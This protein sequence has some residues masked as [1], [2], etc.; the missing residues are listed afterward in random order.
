MDSP[1]SLDSLF[2]EKLFRIPDYQRG[3]A[4]QRDQL[5][6]FWEDLVNLPND[7]TH[8]T[9][10]LTLKEV[11]STE[12]TKDANE[13]WLVDDHSY[14]LHHI[15]DGQ[16]RLTTFVIFIQ[17]LLDVIRAAPGNTDLSDEAI[18]LTESLNL[19]SIRQKY[20]FET[21]PT[22]IPY[23]TYKFGYAIDNPSY[24]FL[25]H[26]ILGESGEGTIEETFYTLNLSNA[27]RFFEEQL[28][29][30]R[31][32]RGL[33][34]I[35]EIYRKLTKRFLF[36]EY[37]IHDEFDV[38]VAFET[39]NNRGKRLSDLELLK[40]RLIY[41]TTLY[42]DQ[43]MDPA[44]R[45]RLR[46][47]VNDAWKEV[48]YQLGRNRNHPLNDDDFLRAHWTMFF[49]YSRQT[50]RDYIQFLLNQQFTPQRI[51]KKIANNVALDAADEVSAGLED[52]ENEPAES[53]AEQLP[54]LTADLK[55]EAI[56]EYVSSLKESACLWFDTF[57]PER[58]TTRSQA[59]QEQ[60]AKLNRIGIGYFRPLVM[61]ILKAVGAEADRL[62]LFKRIERFIFLAFRIGTANS[63]YSSSEFNNA[64]RAI[65][66]REIS[67]AQLCAKLDERLRYAVNEDG[68][69]R[70]DGF[71][72]LL[73]RRFTNG[74]GYYG[75]TALRYFLYEYEVSLLAE[76]RQKKVD[77][78]DLL[79]SEKDMISIE[80]IF[81]QTAGGPWASAF[82]TV[83]EPTRARYCG[84]LGNLLLL[85]ASINSS[86]QNDS[87]A[88][89]KQPRF[90]DGGRK[91]RNG[92]ADG[93]H[94]E[95][96]VSQL[97]DWGPVQIHERGIKLLRFME[98]RWDIR[99]R[100]E[101]RERLLFLGMS[102]TP[103]ASASSNGDEVAPAASE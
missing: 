9:G 101:D 1:Q 75:W 32:T 82:A 41:L 54:R 20:L 88:E 44:D 69:F 7:R 76:S 80:H 35:E 46:E 36:N 97:D 52:D 85:S 13:Y 86:L 8:Y 29:A 65:D 15:V 102:T 91:I 18:Y 74:G 94:S 10:V 16:Q 71:Y 51:H 49:K 40:N 48:Y 39:M 27:K 92:Y 95:I 14:K 47:D 56:R 21:K 63:N 96:E 30:W 83:D 5:K 22:G 64:V 43:E 12:I 78:N 53:F 98:K 77:W 73:V 33:A 93:S 58:S 84:S 60:L 19:T 6:A 23:R 28:H 70:I 24:E 31:E 34:G 103:S 4:W 59:E 25:R 72:N 2:K 17:A 100:D 37:I 55:P 79:K 26:R 67:A 57:F 11:S 61:A 68:T 99:L 62:L 42:S 81:P 90:D 50:G 66:R 38:F 89:K 45:R 3:Y 87:F